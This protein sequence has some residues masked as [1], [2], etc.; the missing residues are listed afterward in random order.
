[1]NNL[2]YTKTYNHM[3]FKEAESR[4]YDMNNHFW[5]LIDNICSMHPEVEVTAEHFLVKPVFVSGL[6]EDVRFLCDCSKLLADFQQV[7]QKHYHLVPLRLKEP[8]KETDE[9][10]QD[11]Q[12][13]I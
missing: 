1:M 5:V 4:L 10:F 8:Y 2:K 11:V 13:H 6:A 7:Y 9:I 12:E 3:F